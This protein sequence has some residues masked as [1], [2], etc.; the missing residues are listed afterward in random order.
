MNN[1]IIRESERAHYLMQLAS[2]F[3]EL[4]DMPDVS[5]AYTHNVSDTWYN[6]AYG[7]NIKNDDSVSKAIDRLLDTSKAFFDARNREMCFYLTPASSPSNLGEILETKGF[8]VFDE[9]AWMF[10][11]PKMY[12]TPTLNP[13]VKV[14]EVTED[15]LSIFDDVYRR[16][17]PGPE[18]DG[19]IDCVVNGFKSNPPLVC[20]K[21]YLAYYGEKAVGMLSLLTLGKYAGLYAIAVDE[22]CQRRGVCKAMLSAALEYCTLNSIQYVFLQTG[23]KTDAETA[24][25]KMGFKTEFV[26]IGYT[27][28]S[29]VDNI[30]HG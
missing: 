2:Y 24:F 28:E 19:Y 8:A 11:N 23:H 5:Y 26:R 21:Y 15:M 14:V 7:I 3:S 30:Q 20:I 27:K 1:Q 4:T 9:E 22:D 17:L 12:Q 29:I 16:T 13:N 25:E 10:I 6:Q 18:V